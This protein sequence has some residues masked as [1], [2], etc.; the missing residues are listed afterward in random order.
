MLAGLFSAALEHVHTIIQMDR[1]RRKARARLRIDQAACEKALS[2]YRFV[3][4]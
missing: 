2:V 3:D 1:G 4:Y